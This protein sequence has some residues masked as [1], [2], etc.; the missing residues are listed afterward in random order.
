MIN[1][2]V[3]DF[4]ITMYWI[5]EYLFFEHDYN[6]AYLPDQKHSNT[7]NKISRKSVWDWEFELT[8]SRD[9]TRLYLSSS[10]ANC[11]HITLGE[12]RMSRPEKFEN[13]DIKEAIREIKKFITDCGGEV[14]LKTEQ[15]FKQKKVDCDFTFEKIRTSYLDCNLLRIENNLFFRLIDHSLYTNDYS[16]VLQGAIL[17]KTEH[18]K[19]EISSY[20]Y[21]YFDSEKS[22][23]CVGIAGIGGILTRRLVFDNYKDSKN[24]K[25]V[26]EEIKKEIIKIGNSKELKDKYAS[27]F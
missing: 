17:S 11:I 5:G 7:L 1:K 16:I 21:I 4:K 20:T 13:V 18:L 24:A 22:Q 2:T 10:S 25:F 19:I 3:Y 23:V 14:V 8:A 12:E 27:S 15:D 6:L 9:Y 26:F